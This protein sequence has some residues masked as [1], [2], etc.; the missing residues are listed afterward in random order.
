MSRQPLFPFTLL[1]LS[2]GCAR[3]PDADLQYIKQARSIAAEWA[4]VNEQG[5][6]GQLTGTY[7]AAMHDWLHDGLL[8]AS[9][10]LS[11]PNSRYGVEIRALLAAPPDAPPA[12]LRSHGEVL[13]QIEDT[14]ESA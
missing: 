3:A 8:T 11:Q 1:A 14:L 13:K 10:S 4:L 6:A 2:V 7:V 5:H 9:T 12:M